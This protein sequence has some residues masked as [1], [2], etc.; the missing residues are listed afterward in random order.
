V[1]IM[2]D[3]IIKVLFGSEVTREEIKAASILE[4]GDDLG[5]AERLQLRELCLGCRN[6]ENVANII[7]A[8][9]AARSLA[10]HL[11]LSLIT[12]QLCS[13]T[14]SGLP[15][16]FAYGVTLGAFRSINWLDR[17]WQIET[18]F[19]ACFVEIVPNLVLHNCYSQ[20]LI[21]RDPAYDDQL[22]EAVKAYPSGAQYYSGKRLVDCYHLLQAIEKHIARWKMKDQDI[23]DIGKLGYRSINGWYLRRFFKIIWLVNS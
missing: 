9:T 15:I 1:K 2:D 22:S 14:N 3:A 19:D 10:S 16:V 23:S 18:K 12:E 6:Y 13:E 17:N 8:T 21:K 4:V 7:V 11:W 20:T 5:D